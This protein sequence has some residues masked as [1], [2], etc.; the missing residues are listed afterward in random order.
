MWH[1]QCNL[2]RNI[3]V[4]QVARKFFSY[5]HL[6]AI[7]IRKKFPSYDYICIYLYWTAWRHANPKLFTGV[8]KRFNAVIH[9]LAD[10]YYAT[11]LSCVLTVT[12]KMERLSKRWQ[13][14]VLNASALLRLKTHSFVLL[15]RQSLVITQRPCVIIICYYRLKWT[16]TRS[17]PR[18]IWSCRKEHS[19]QERSRTVAD[20]RYW[21]A[22]L[23][24]TMHHVGAPWPC[25]F[26][27]HVVVRHSG[28]INFLRAVRS[29]R[30]W[31]GWC[32]S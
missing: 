20:H 27:L 12:I 11:P 9:I 32:T 19:D 23:R 14:M 2:Q 30:F 21:S 16:G 17:T 6:R 18:S 26:V 5:L 10:S 1:D 7:T 25:W 31:I 22:T 29:L 4:R 24:H 3:C 28:N 8:W 15:K 13:A